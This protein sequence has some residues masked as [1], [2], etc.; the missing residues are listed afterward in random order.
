MKNNIL[1]KENYKDFFYD[2]VV[3]G[4]S[5][6]YIFIQYELVIPSRKEEIDIFDEIINWYI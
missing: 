3:L 4:G 6:A 5:D 1:K 2:F